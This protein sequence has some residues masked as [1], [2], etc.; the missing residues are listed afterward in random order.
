MKEEG[1]PPAMGFSGQVAFRL[2][3]RPVAS[4]LLVPLLRCWLLSPLSAV[5]RPPWYLRGRQR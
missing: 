3:L 2:P 4:A 5:R 1:F